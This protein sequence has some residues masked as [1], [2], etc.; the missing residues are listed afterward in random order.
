ME[1][2]G[3]GYKVIEMPQKAEV[4]GSKSYCSIE[5]GLCLYPQ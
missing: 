1:C 4:C 2:L 5:S 3:E